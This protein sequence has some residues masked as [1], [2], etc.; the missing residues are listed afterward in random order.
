MEGL[1]LKI[2]LHWKTLGRRL[3]IKEAVL[4]AIHKQEVECSEKAYKMLLKWKQAGGK[5][6]T[7]LVLYDALCHDYLNRKDLAEEFCCVG[8]NQ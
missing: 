5:R 2:P 8:H 4:D 6:A 7:F 3:K 1:A